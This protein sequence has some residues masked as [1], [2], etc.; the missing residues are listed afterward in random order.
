M[1]HFIKM[2]G[3]IY[4]FISVLFSLM[5]MADNSKK[6]KKKK[7][8]TTNNYIIPCYNVF[9]QCDM[10]FH[11][12]FSQCAMIDTFIFHRL[13]YMTYFFTFHC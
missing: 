12:K 6:K 2:D 8:S 13:T 10:I 7:Y 9:G 3:Y 5:I 4:I 11:I 1:Y